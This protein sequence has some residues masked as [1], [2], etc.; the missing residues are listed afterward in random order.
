[1][2]ISGI[3]KV[4]QLVDW[5]P[6]HREQARTDVQRMKD[7]NLLLNTDKKQIT[8]YKARIER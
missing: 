2:A 6:G 5:L 3:Q 8:T 1:M 7:E 4:F